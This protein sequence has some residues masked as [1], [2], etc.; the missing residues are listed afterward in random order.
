[1]C[2]SDGASSASSISTERPS[3]AE[4]M[5]QQRRDWPLV[6]HVSAV[7]HACAMQPTLE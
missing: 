4:V 7:Q 3:H 6:D 2:L 5:D 1:M